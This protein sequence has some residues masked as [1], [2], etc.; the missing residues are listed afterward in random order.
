MG[1]ITFWEEQVMFLKTNLFLLQEIVVE[2]W[3]YHDYN[4]Q[5]HLCFVV[6]IDEKSA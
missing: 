6:W 3:N 2:I 5:K 4:I 1:F